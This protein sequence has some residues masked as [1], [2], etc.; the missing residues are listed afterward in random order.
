M[1]LVAF[2]TFDWHSI[3]PATLKRMPTG[4]ITVMIVT[5]VVVATHNLA[6]GVI[7]VC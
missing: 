2:A 6:I 1:V 3:A 5:I 4:E 7:A